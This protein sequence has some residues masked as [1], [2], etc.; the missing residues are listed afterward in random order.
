MVQC[1]PSNLQFCCN[2]AAILLE[3][4]E[5]LNTSLN[6]SKIAANDTYFFYFHLWKKIM[7]GV[8]CE[9]PAQQRTHMKYQI[10]FSLKNN[11]KTM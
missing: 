6:S 3:L 11:L 8:S 5:V 4:S 10:H 1:F 9:S 7:L 2:F